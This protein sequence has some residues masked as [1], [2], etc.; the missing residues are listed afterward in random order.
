[1]ECFVCWQGSWCVQQTGDSEQP[2][3]LYNR[4]CYTRLQDR[5]LLSRL[6]KGKQKAQECQRRQHMVFKNIHVMD[7]G[8]GKGWWFLD[9]LIF[10]R[11]MGNVGSS[12]TAG[13]P[14]CSAAENLKEI[15]RDGGGLGTTPPVLSRS[16]K[17]Q[18][19]VCRACHLWCVPSALT[20]SAIA[21]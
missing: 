18:G 14:H 6:F 2:V 15:T 11:E 5:P 17:H 9:T 12:L 4:S 20:Q 19:S 8:V 1:M 21:F 13:W 3:T 7:I 10:T 16:L